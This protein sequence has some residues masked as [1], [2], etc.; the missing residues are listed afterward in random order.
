MMTVQAGQMGLFTICRHAVVDVLHFGR[1]AVSKFSVLLLCFVPDSVCVEPSEEGIS[2][3][4]RFLLF[5]PSRVSKRGSLYS[6]KG[7]NTEAD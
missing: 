3:H 7:P 2:L 5:P 1:P 4:T 6:Y